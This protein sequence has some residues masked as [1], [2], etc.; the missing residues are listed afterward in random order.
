MKSRYPK[1]QIPREPHNAVHRHPDPVRE[2][3][4]GEATG[5]PGVLDDERADTVAGAL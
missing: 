4:N 1:C 3:V 2:V 5:L